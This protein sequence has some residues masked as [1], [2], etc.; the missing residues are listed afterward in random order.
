MHLLPRDEKLFDLL[1]EQA[2]IVSAASILLPKELAVGDGR[3]DWSAMALKVRDLECKGDE[4]TR[5]IYRCLHKTFITPI[6][7]ED[8]HA[9]AT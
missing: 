3:Q 6:D 1:I 5:N 9:L 8:L 4:A 2:H 7:P